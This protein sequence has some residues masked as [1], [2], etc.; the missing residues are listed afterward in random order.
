MKLSRTAFISLMAS[1]TLLTL[2]TQAAENLKIEKPKFYGSIDLSFAFE[3]ADE[4]AL[5]F[6][7]APG[8]N[9]YIGLTGS[10]EFS[11][12]SKLTYLHE[13][14]VNL[15]GGSGFAGSYQSYVGYQQSNYEVRV[16]NQHLP[17]RRALDKTDIFSGTYADH[18]NIVIPNTTAS[19]S[20]LFLSGNDTFNYAISLDTASQH[21]ENANH[22]D[23]LDGVRL[24]GMI[25]Y[26]ISDVLSIAGGLELQRDDIT[27][28]NAIGV[29]MNLGITDTIE[30]VG[31]LSR[32][33]FEVCTS[34]PDKG[35]APLTLTVGG[36]MKLDND[37]TL[38]AIIGMQD[39]DIK[40]VDDPRMIAF[41]V[42]KV[43]V[44]PLVVYGLIAL[45]DNGGL[46]GAS[47]PSGGS[48][49][50]ADGDGKAN[51]LSVGARFT[52]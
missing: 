4:Y 48:P 39:A 41:G 47:F 36:N 46:R 6:E 31:S 37:I 7:D 52:F 28:Y 38:K 18:N 27:G 1:T 15:T 24:G 13:E 45:G 30:L 34:N 49:L 25:D 44:E 2:N 21:A 50:E 23:S 16:G 42:D 33:D 51:V 9:N 22:E 5:A 12:G 11:D 3:K 17:L 10:F 19:S 20:A 43:I 40:G 8:D 26:T 32:V 29:S 35:C 14:I